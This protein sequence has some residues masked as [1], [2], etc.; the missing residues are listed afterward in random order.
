[1]EWTQQML[2][3]YLGRVRLVVEFQ[4]LSEGEFSAALEQEALRR[5]GRV[6]EVVFNGEMQDREKIQLL[7]TWF[8]Q[9]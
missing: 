2:A 4:G 6:E 9:S 1:M 7:Q 8:T 3:R 5:L